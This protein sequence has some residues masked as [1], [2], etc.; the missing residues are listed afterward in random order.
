MK[1][2]L[3]SRSDSEDAGSSFRSGRDAR[4]G[5][6]G[7][8]KFPKRLIVIG[9]FSYRAAAIDSVHSEPEASKRVD[10]PPSVGKAADFYLEHSKAK[11]KRVVLSLTYLLRQRS[12][13]RLLIRSSD[14]LFAI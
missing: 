5:S 13:E 2:L 9:S 3:L 11:P 10:S 1:R 7:T 8:S 14:K 6:P 4:L 12:L